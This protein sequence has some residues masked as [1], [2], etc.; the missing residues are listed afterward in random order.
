[1]WLTIEDKKCN[2]DARNISTIIDDYYISPKTATLF[3]KKKNKHCLRNK[4]KINQ[5]RFDNLL[6]DSLTQMSIIPFFPSLKPP[7]ANCIWFDSAPI[8]EEAEILKYERE[9]HTWVVGI[10]VSHICL[11]L[12]NWTSKMNTLVC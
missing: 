5:N 3:V 11:N 12:I 4:T 6:T 7:I 9:H 2:C 10:S 1:M 8:N